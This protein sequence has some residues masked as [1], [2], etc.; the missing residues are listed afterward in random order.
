MR[1]FLFTFFII[2]FGVS[3]YGQ[4]FDGYV[5]TNESDTIHCKFFVQ[6]NF[7]NKNIFYATSV[8]KSVKI[9]SDSGEK[10][11]YYP[12]DIK[13]FFIK[14]TT[15]G[16]FNFVSFKED[17]YK[18]FYH[19]VVKDRLSYYRLYTTQGTTFANAIFKE[20]VYKDNI[21]LELGLFNTRKNLANLINDNKVI[22]DKWM[23][24]HGYYKLKD[25][26]NIINQYNES[27]K[28]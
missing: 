2:G 18:H 19:E 9:L 15:D 21:F 4:A 11:K 10:I 7:I 23:D 13:C 5:V 17:G 28:K 16:D 1:F 8:Y 25:A 20:F 22:Y 3:L 24:E 12:K 6:T 27:Y 26:F 14:G